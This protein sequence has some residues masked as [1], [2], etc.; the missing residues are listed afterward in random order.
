MVSTMKMIF[1][2]GNRMTKFEVGMIEPRY[3]VRASYAELDGCLIDHLVRERRY[4]GSLNREKAFLSPLV[5]DNGCAR[6]F[7][8]LPPA[9]W[10]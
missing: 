6:I 8:G 7:E 4:S 10:S 9:M 5:R 1:C 3:S 2:L